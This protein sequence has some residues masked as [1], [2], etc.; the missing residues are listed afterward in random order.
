MRLLLV[1]ASAAFITVSSRVLAQ[2]TENPTPNT[3][4]DVSD[5]PHELEPLENLIVYPEAA[6]RSGLEGKVTVDLLIASDGHVD[7]VIVQQ[8]D[9]DIFEDA[10]ID[11]IQRAHFIPA[12]NNG[13]PVK[14]WVTRTINFKLQG[15]S[16]LKYFSGLLG[17]SKAEA[18]GRFQEV[19]NLDEEEET[20]GIH[21]HAESRTGFSRG[22]HP[23]A[24]DGIIGDNGMNQLTIY[25]HCENDDDFNIVT[26]I[27]KVN[28]FSGGK[29]TSVSARAEFPSML[30]SVDLD[31]AKRTLRINLRSK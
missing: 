4:V 22:R 26:S 3:F 27:W 12:K 17:A 13:I 31:A 9:Y 10:A 28:K 24:L 8:S 1:L 2:T 29:L 23:S 6:R 7:S 19:G 20:D 30:M 25:Y 11:A 5:E 21:L 18:L 14:V 15:G 16:Q